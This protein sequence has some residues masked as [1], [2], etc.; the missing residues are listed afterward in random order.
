MPLDTVNLQFSYNAEKVYKFPD[1]KLSSSEAALIIGPSGSGKTTF[2]NLIA[3]LQKAS[4]GDVTI[5]NQS[6]AKLEGKN[7]EQFRAQHLGLIFQKS[8]FLPYLSILD[9]MKLI[10]SIQNRKASTEEITDLFTE[11][12]I[13]HILNKKASAC[14]TG[15][16]QRAA[17][18][19]ALL[20]KPSLILADEPTAALD[21]EN[22]QKVGELL[23]K[24]S[25]SQKTALLIVTHDGRLKKLI[26]KSYQL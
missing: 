3:G 9:N 5:N 22:A 4:K 26:S 16:Q 8:L 6:L 19:R 10:Y 15:E 13:K 23:L 7:L 25:Q 12:N 20:Q 21:D 17:I 18:A 24:M 14:S 11:L 1:I 2:L